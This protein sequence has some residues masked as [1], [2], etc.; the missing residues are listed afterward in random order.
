MQILFANG[1]V[2]TKR[3]PKSKTFVKVFLYFNLYHSFLSSFAD[4]IDE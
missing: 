1:N 3:M 4:S 2:L